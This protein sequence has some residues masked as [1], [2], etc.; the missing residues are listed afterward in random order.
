MVTGTIEL[1]LAKKIWV[2]AFE[3]RKLLNTLDGWLCKRQSSELGGKCV[4][5]RTAH[6]GGYAVGNEDKWNRSPSLACAP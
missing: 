1:K 5:V 4:R 3:T 6:V 2:L